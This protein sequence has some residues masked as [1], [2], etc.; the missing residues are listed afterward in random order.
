MRWRLRGAAMWPAFGLAVV[1]DAV[2][3]RL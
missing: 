2:I 1:V 3:L